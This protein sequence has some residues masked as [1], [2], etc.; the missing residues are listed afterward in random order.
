MKTAIIFKEK[1]LIT[2]SKSL[3]IFKII[4]KNDKEL[5]LKEL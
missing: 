4:E 3:K 1:Y 5:E 2:A